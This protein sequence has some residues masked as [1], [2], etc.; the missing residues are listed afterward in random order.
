MRVGIIRS[1]DTQQRAW[2]P[3]EAS[4]MSDLPTKIVALVMLVAF[5]RGKIVSSLLFL[6]KKKFQDVT[7]NQIVSYHS[8]DLLLWNYYFFS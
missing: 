4:L 5:L 8:T 3:L 7:D 1:L 6:K 2:L